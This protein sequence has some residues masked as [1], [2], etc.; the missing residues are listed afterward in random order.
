MKTRPAFTRRGFVTL[1]M[2]K[3]LVASA[4]FPIL[5]T[6]G[7]FR[8]LRTQMASGR[9][10]RRTTTAVGRSET[11]RHAPRAGLVMMV[12]R[13]IRAFRDGAPFGVGRALRI[14]GLSGMPATEHARGNPLLQF[15]H[16]EWQWILHLISPP[17]CLRV[18]GA[19]GP[20][21]AGSA[22]AAKFAFGS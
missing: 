16:F 10:P 17:F 15:L 19:T 6:T 8:A 11:G 4:A 21:C 14:G 7:A 9:G 13:G 1:V 5:G 18:I 2:G 12:A 20:A 22:C 3:A